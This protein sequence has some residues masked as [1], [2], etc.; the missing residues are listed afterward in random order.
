MPPV[1]LVFGAGINHSLVDKSSRVVR[2]LLSWR[3]LLRHL[4]WYPLDPPPEDRYPQISQSKT[5]WQKYLRKKFRDSESEENFIRRVSLIEAMLA[6]NPDAERFAA[7]AHLMRHEMKAELIDEKTKKRG[8]LWDIAMGRVMKKLC[9]HAKI[10]AWDPVLRRAGTLAR[11][12]RVKL[13]TTNFDS[14]IGRK[15]R[16]PVLATPDATT[17]EAARQRPLDLWTPNPHGGGTPFSSGLHA[18]NLLH[19]IPFAWES[20][21]TGKGSLKES[22]AAEVASVLHIHGWGGSPKG[23][24]FGTVEYHEAGKAADSRQCPNDVIERILRK[25]C[26]TIFLGTS[27]GLMDSHLLKIWSNAS[28]GELGANWWL[29]NSVYDGEKVLRKWEERTQSEEF[30]T[31]VQPVW[32]GKNDLAGAVPKVVMSLF[33]EL[34]RR[35]Q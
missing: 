20:W 33:D 2:E 30:S 28:K 7:V 6:N 17:A 3:G 32:H 29:L 25:D 24:I 27:E 12:G 26:I 22:L 16:L 5:S 10:S 4:A 9:S 35:E 14:L 18:Y 11:Q 23:I 1:A 19:W 13:L 31:H 21:R 34:E 15:A 8:D